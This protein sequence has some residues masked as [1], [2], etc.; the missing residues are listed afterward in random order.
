MRNRTAIVAAA[1]I[2]TGSLHAA[3][4]EPA[5]R[6]VRTADGQ[7]GYQVLGDAR[8]ALPVIVVNGGPGLSHAYLMMND[9]WP[10]IAKGRTVVLYDQRGT[11]ASKAMR[12]G[13][14]QTMEAQV[15]DLEAVRS[16]LGLERFALVGDS[17]GGMIA[18]AYAAAHP[19]HVA[20]LVL[21]DSAAP[22]WKSMVHLLPQAF[23]D[24]E[25]SDEA[26][27]ARLGAGSEAAARASL[28][29]HFS[30]IFYSPAKR[31]AYM[32]RMGDLGFEPEVSQAVSKATADLDLTPKLAAFSFPTLV[33]TGRYDMNVAPLTAWRIA[34]EIPHARMVVFEKSG[35]L[36]A[37][38]E[39]DRYRQVLTAFLSEP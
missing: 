27:E 30:M 15:A 18:M 9:L 2:A 31:D 5:T 22:S 32:A 21:S 35:H 8:S 36:P 1:L 19:E 33:I 16:A 11:G 23:P 28:R 39:P 24:I 13:A 37:Y 3:S 25:A 14:L 4:A 34:H 6:R 29:A 38:E 20:K 17:F 7:I 10:K 12:A 26:E